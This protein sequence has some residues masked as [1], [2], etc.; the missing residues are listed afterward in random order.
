[1]DTFEF[2][3][4]L[5][6]DTGATPA[7]GGSQSASVAPRDQNIS[8]SP[9]DPTDVSVP[10]TVTESTAAFTPS[11]PSVDLSEAERLEAAASLESRLEAYNNKITALENYIASMNAAGHGTES[12][13]GESVASE[14]DPVAAEF[15]AIKGSLRELTGAVQEMRN[16]WNNAVREHARINEAQQLSRVKERA[17]ADVMTWLKDTV[18]KNDPEL[19]RFPDKGISAILL[20][21]VEAFM[22][23]S[24]RPSFR[25]HEIQAQAADLR[26]MVAER[27]KYL[28]SIMPP[29]QP[30]PVREQ[31]EARDAAARNN[32]TATSG[33]TPAPGVPAGPAP[34]T[35]HWFREKLEARARAR[36]LL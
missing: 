31:I 25:T 6:P 36:G 11:A 29:V 8:A 1:M 16:N 4:D 23:N 22:D 27:I 12:E 17:K 15:N 34:G 28:K 18:I 32:L 10:E 24:F 7:A 5:E 19:A 20:S 30:E 9:S 14:D 26:R 2:V 21:D 35:V 3:P 13:T 33:G